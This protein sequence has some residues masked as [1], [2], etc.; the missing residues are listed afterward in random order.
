MYFQTGK[1]QNFAALISSSEQNSAKI[2]SLKAL[3]EKLKG[4]PKSAIAMY[5][6][7]VKKSPKN[8]TLYINMAAV[9]QESGEFDKA[10]EIL[11]QGILMQKN[12]SR[13]YTAAA[14]LTHKAGD[15]IK[16]KEYAN[17]AIK[18]NENSPQ[19]KEILS[20]VN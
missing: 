14:A 20:L 2:L 8:D 18:L 17:S 3:S 16:A 13:L 6:E 15:D 12:S 10:L 9:Y 1:Y 7:A 11:E 19:A 4:D 5:S